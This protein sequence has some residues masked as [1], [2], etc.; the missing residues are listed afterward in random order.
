MS[1]VVHSFGNLRFHADYESPAQRLIDANALLVDLEFAKPD[2]APESAGL[3]VVKQ[4]VCERAGCGCPALPS[5]A[6]YTLGGPVNST[7]FQ[8]SHC[9]SRPPTSVQ[10]SRTST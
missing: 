2:G 1:R 9:R 6:K 3:A 10:V 7:A 8:R 5:S 4:M